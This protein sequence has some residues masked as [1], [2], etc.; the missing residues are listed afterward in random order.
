MHCCCENLQTSVKRNE[1]VYNKLRGC[2]WFYIKCDYDD[3]YGLYRLG[4]CPFCG[5]QLPKDRMDE[6][7][8]ILEKDYGIMLC[9]VDPRDPSTYPPEFQT[10]EWWRKRGL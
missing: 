3:S 5:T 2:F 10:D 1:I 6:F 4:Y 8:E 9:D 7:E